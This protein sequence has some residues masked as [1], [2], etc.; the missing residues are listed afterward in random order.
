M[1][2]PEFIT[3]ILPK[4]SYDILKKIITSLFSRGIVLDFVEPCP[5]EIFAAALSYDM[6]SKIGIP[7]RFIV[8]NN[9]KEHN[10]LQEITVKL[11]GL[12]NVG[13]DGRFGELSESNTSKSIE[14]PRPFY[15]GER[16]DVR[17]KGQIFVKHSDAHKFAEEFCG[18]RD[19]HVGIKLVYTVREGHKT[20]TREL[21]KGN[22]DFY[23]RFHPHYI[24]SLRGSCGN[25]KIA[26]LLKK[27]LLDK[28]I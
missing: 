16:L 3:A 21:E 28:K 25:E 2:L 23:R 7:L 27:V 5:V 17:L 14:L 6:P 10:Y 15:P 26:G 4:I 12:E 24:L 1:P 20:K 8:L 9:G 22:I 18:L 11:H 19:K 13:W